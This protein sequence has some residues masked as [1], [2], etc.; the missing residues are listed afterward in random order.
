MHTARTSAHGSS[1]AVPKS[2]AFTVSVEAWRPPA[3]ARAACARWL[4]ASADRSAVARGRR[5]S[6]IS[7]F[8]GG[9]A[10]PPNAAGTTA[11]LANDRPPG[12]TG[13]VGSPLGPLGT[14]VL[15]GGTDGIAGMAGTSGTLG[16]LGTGIGVG[17]LDG[18]GALGVLG[19]GS[20]AGLLDGIGATGA[21][22]NGSGAGLLDGVGLLDGADGGI[23]TGAG[24]TTGGGTVSDGVTRGRT[25]I[26]GGSIGSGPGLLDAGAD[27]GVTG[28]GITGAGGVSDSEGFDRGGSGVPDGKSGGVVELE[29]GG[30]GAGFAVT[31][32]D[33]VA[34][35]GGGSIVVKP[36]FGTNAGGVFAGFALVAGAD[37]AAGIAGG[38]GGVG[39]F[40]PKMRFNRPGFSSSCG[41]DMVGLVS[42]EAPD[43]C[44]C[45]R[46]ENTEMP[47]NRR[48]FSFAFDWSGI[49]PDVGASSGSAGRGVIFGVPVLVAFDF[50]GSAP[51][52]PAGGIG[53]ASPGRSSRLNVSPVFVSLTSERYVPSGCFSDFSTFTWRSEP[54]ANLRVMTSPTLGTPWG[55]SPPLGAADRPTATVAPTTPAHTHRFQNHRI[56]A[57]SVRSGTVAGAPGAGTANPFASRPAG[58][59]EASVPGVRIGLPGF[60]G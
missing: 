8:I 29:T 31:G 58:V 21:L 10:D 47:G 41:A 22:G 25:G 3:I 14:G 34:R 53:G 26:G 1:C 15:A 52:E 49:A 60:A 50:G 56:M 28:T 19:S 18:M 7:A 54:L 30:F 4:G 9:I 38:A 13:I 27:G 20:G 2:I 43:D 11:G 45:G 33:G 36:V 40:F 5:S 48:S 17:L 24:M 6:I 51:F 59:A 42:G 57:D 12:G 39:V 37:G 32:A 55:M 44:V 16:A 35:T 46:D 23:G